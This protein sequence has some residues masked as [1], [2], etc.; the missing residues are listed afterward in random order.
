MG[1]PKGSIHGLVFFLLYINV[2]P[3]DVICNIGVYVND[4]TLCSKFDQSSDLWQQLAG[5]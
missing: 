2:P 4:T 3:D 1:N 5:F